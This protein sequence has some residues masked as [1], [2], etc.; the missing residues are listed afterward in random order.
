LVPR[1]ERLHHREP[2]DA[3][4]RDRRLGA[5]GEHH[6]RFA[7]LDGTVGVAHVARARGARCDHAAVGPQHAVAHGYVPGRHV[8]DEHGDEERAHPHGAALHADLRLSL[9]GLE[10]T[11]ARADAHAGQLTSDLVLAQAGVLQRVRGADHG[12]LHEAV[13][14]LGL[15]AVEV[16]AD[17]DI[18]LARDADAEVRRVEVGD[19][20]DAVLGGVLTFEERGCAHADWRDGTHSG[21]DDSSHRHAK[22]TRPAAR[23]GCRPAA[24]SASAAPLRPLRRTTL[25]PAAVVFEGRLLLVADELHG[26]A[27]RADTFRLFVGDLHA[28]LVLQAHDQLDDVERVGAQVFDE[29]GIGRDLAWIGV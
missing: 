29:A 23:D 14:A 25:A 2:A 28:E 4:G 20:A 11:D 21:Y 9:P 22:G 8:G 10:A 3:H 17:V 1:R 24:M 12:Q 6:L 16:L 18:D 27:D 13:E 19:L 5:A 26:V 7:A 15:L